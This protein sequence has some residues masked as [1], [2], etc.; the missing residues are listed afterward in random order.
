M[1]AA[2]RRKQVSKYAETLDAYGIERVC[3][4]ILDGESLNSTAKDAG[5]P[6][7]ALLYWCET[8]AARAL[9]LRE[10]RRRAAKVWDEQAEMHILRAPD[11]F[12]LA[13]A[14]EVAHHLR[15]RAAMINPKEYAGRMIHEQTGPAGGPI[16][17][18]ATDLRG[19]SDEELEIMQRLMTKANSLSNSGID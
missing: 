7:H 10:T 5:V 1:D 13:K 15:W 14:R 16:Q 9:L 2:A 12:S 19:L 8:N 18:Q 11:K 3:D 6:L 17:V 4:R